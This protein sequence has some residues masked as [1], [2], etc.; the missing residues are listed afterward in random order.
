MASVTDTR[1]DFTVID[2]WYV[3]QASKCTLVLTRQ[4][5]I[6]SLK[7]GRWWKRKQA[8][9]ARHPQEET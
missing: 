4:Q 2:G 9:A 3:I 1:L 7:R 5:F 8:F 6:E